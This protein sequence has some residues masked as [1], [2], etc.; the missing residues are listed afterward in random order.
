MYKNLNLVQ[1]GESYILKADSERFGKQAIIFQSPLEKDL[2][3]FLMENRLVL[4]FVDNTSITNLRSIEGRELIGY[5]RMYYSG[6]WDG[7]WFPESRKKID[8]SELAGLKNVI[9][10]V[11]ERWT[12]GCDYIMSYE[13]E[14]EHTPWGSENRF[15]LQPRGNDYYLVMIDTTYGNGDYPVRIYVYRDDITQWDKNVCPVDCPC[16]EDYPNC[17]CQEIMDEA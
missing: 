12:K 8:D 7:R 16:K 1:N 5:Y 3:R 2:D 17:Y 15:L 6:R 14:Q 4:N 10:Y 11:A 13:M 9:N